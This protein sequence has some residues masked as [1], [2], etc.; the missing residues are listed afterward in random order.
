MTTP[1]VA[2]GATASHVIPDLAYAVFGERQG[3]WRLDSLFGDRDLAVFDAQQLARRRHYRAVKVELRPDS[4]AAA[5][6][7]AGPRSSPSAPLPCAPRR[8]S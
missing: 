7:V 6:A 2:A 4:A 3:R 5:A 1:S 8:W